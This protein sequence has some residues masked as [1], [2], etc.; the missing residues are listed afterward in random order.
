MFRLSVFVLVRGE[1]LNGERIVRNLGQCSA[2]PESCSLFPVHFGL[3]LTVFKI[4][5]HIIP[6]THIQIQIPKH[7]LKPN[8]NS[9][10]EAASLDGS[11]HSS[12]Q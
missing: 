12:P 1:Y 10:Q 9:F 5:N 4:L 6:Q 3:L 8:I 11:H 2:F 7:I